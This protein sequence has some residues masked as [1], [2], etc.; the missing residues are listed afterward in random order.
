MKCEQC[1][2]EFE[3][4]PQ[5]LFCSAKCQGKSWRK[6]GPHGYPS[7]TFV[8]AKCGK[9]VTTEGGKDRRSRFCCRECEKKF[10]KHPPHDNPSTRTNFK[11]I[12]EYASYERRT[13]E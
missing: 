1:G 3:P 12:Q 2:K 4:K 10:W 13:N 11:S 9:T 6:N 8:C 7:I 5:Q